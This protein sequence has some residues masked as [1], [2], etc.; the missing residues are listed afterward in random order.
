V[1]RDGKFGPFN[2]ATIII[3]QQPT[4]TITPTPGITLTPT[5][6]QT[7]GT[8]L[9]LTPTPTATQSSTVLTLESSGANDGFVLESSETS[10]KG[11]SMNN[12][13]TNINIGDNAK[14]K[15]Y[16]GILS[17]DTGTGL[18]DN[19]VIT[20]ITLQIKKQTLIGGGNPV[21]IFHGFM[22]DIKNGTFGTAAL[23]NSDFQ[24]TANK[25]YGP[26]TPALIGGWYSIN[27]TSANANI[28]KVGL[29]QLR[30]R[31]ALD[32]NNNAVANYLSIFSGNAPA[33]NR[34]LLI[35]TYH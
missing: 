11:G 16:R 19:A 15:Q 21:T 3:G 31:F 8:P 24:A 26:F 20:A 34:P 29:T 2:N 28:N 1:D 30:L 7:P 22:V 18:P 25:A 5:R 13:A 10:V 33:A 6:T 12:T 17:F 14:K 4:P 27:L 32:D 35:I 9:T 23:Q